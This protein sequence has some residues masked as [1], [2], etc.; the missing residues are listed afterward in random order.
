MQEIELIEQDYLDYIVDPRFVEESLC[1]EYK[2]HLR[3]NP[4]KKKR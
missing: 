2:S 4:N 3:W 1:L